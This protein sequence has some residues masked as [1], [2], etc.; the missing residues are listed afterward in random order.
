MSGDTFYIDFKEIASIKASLY[1]PKDAADCNNLWVILKSGKDF[2]IAYD[3]TVVD[4]GN[5][6]KKTYIQALIK[7]A[8]K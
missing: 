4:I 7:T 5:T 6:G 8:L 2:T 1:P 3:D